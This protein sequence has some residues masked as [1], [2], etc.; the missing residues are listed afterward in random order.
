MTEY[1]IAA[2]HEITGEPITHLVRA[3]CRCGADALATI[4]QA[5]TARCGPCVMEDVER[6]HSR[7]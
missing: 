1:P 2:F 5:P 3:V 7:T 6:A 4:E